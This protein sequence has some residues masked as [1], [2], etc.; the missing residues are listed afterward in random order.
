MKQ[1]DTAV[2]M[3]PVTEAAD[4]PPSP[5]HLVVLGIETCIHCEQPRGSHLK[6]FY[7]CW[8]R[9]TFFEAGPTRA[10]LTKALARADAVL[11]AVWLFTDLDPEHTISCHA[12]SLPEMYRAACA[13]IDAARAAGTPDWEFP[14][15][16]PAVQ[17]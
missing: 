4:T 9:S 14:P 15:E 2:P 12:D 3:E 16:K 7:A 8:E 13:A 1:H 11:E 17:P 10:Q 5:D 6:P